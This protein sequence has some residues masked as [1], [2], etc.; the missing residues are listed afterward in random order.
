MPHLLRLQTMT[1]EALH[2]CLRLRRLDPSFGSQRETFLQ[3]QVSHR[4][5]QVTPGQREP[6]R[7]FPLPLPHPQPYLG[8][9]EAM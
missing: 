2:P 6:S 3:V 1:I 7:L 8:L 4:Y 9:D 5:L